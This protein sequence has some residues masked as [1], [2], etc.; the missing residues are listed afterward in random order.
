M[1]SR[2]YI[3][4]NYSL[5]FPRLRF[6]YAELRRFTE[7]ELSMAWRIEELFDHGSAFVPDV[8]ALCGFQY[9]VVNENAQSRPWTAPGE[10]TFPLNFHPD[11]LERVAVYQ[12]RFPPII[13]RAI[14]CLLLQPIEDAIDYGIDWRPFETPI[15]YIRH[16]DAEGQP[17]PA[18]DPSKLARTP[19]FSADGE[20]Y[21]SPISCGECFRASL[22]DELKGTWQLLEGLLPLE[23]APQSAINPL[24]ERFVLRAYE[25]GRFEGLIMHMI[26]IDAMLGRREN[27]A[28]KK[29]KR[30]ISKLL[31]ITEEEVCFRKHIAKFYRSKHYSKRTSGEWFLHLYKMRND[32]VHGKM[33]ERETV[34]RDNDPFIQDII[35][36][37]ILTRTIFLASC[38]LIES[39]NWTR[40]KLI[41]ELDA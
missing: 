32:Y 3:P 24:V 19:R 5:E 18:P 31:D 16:D 8:G 10:A 30:R 23:G 38:R 7:S 34:C 39:R 2:Y 41:E 6:G 25:Q 26:A 29:T 1:S 13:D 20:D 22:E 27:D 14:F 37:H 9:L 21:Y 4:L 33:I 28:T 35:I 11:R 15:L 17:W 12:R 40:E 36:A